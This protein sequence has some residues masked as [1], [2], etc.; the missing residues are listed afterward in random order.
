MSG[1][2]GDK[3]KRDDLEPKQKKRQRLDPNSEREVNTNLHR[4]HLQPP[5]V[6]GY[7]TQYPSS[8]DPHNPEQPTNEL[9]D[10]EQLE[11]QAVQLQRRLTEARQR[12]SQRGQP[13][14]SPG[15]TQP[16][17][18]YLPTQSS[19]LP[20]GPSDHRAGGY[21]GLSPDYGHLPRQTPP[22]INLS[23]KPRLP[24]HGSSS[25]A[26][27]G[28]GQPVRSS[29]PPASTYPSAPEKL[30][31]TTQGYYPTVSNTGKRN[32]D[33]WTASNESNDTQDNRKVQRRKLDTGLPAI[34]PAPPASAYNLPQPS[35]RD[36]LPSS[37]GL[38]LLGLD[39]TRPSKVLQQGGG[40]P[41]SP[42]D[43]YDPFS[44]FDAF[45]AAEGPTSAVDSTPAQN[46]WDAAFNS[47]PDPPQHQQEPLT[48]NELDAQIRALGQGFPSEDWT[49]AG[50]FAQP[51]NRDPTNSYPTAQH[52]GKQ[53]P[54]NVDSPE[55]G[56][57][58]QRNSQAGS[59]KPQTKRQQRLRRFG[60]QGIELG[61][62]NKKKGAVHY[63]T[64]G[65]MFCLVNGKMVPAAYHH[66]RRN[67]LLERADRVG[68]YSK[69]TA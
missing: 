66:E 1:V 9:D 3:R 53:P 63:N 58:E 42:I 39:S 31:T 40:Q 27:R 51:I 43:P 48:E 17:R 41:I 2:G 23:T 56:V 29:Q 36:Q 6:A 20:Y 12:A 46:P 57:P 35:E 11:I 21:S 49:V 26:P 5:N 45:N 8:Q 67:I 55:L 33:V 68:S 16:P 15:P 32:R 64:T 25:Y 34:P 7:S 61:K 62:D 38:D 18:G 65:N 37:D 10:V 19:T 13:A 69:S 44:F 52:L 14:Q 60:E 4:H 28:T 22:S 59:E 24:G 50:T 30:S 47:F 54:N